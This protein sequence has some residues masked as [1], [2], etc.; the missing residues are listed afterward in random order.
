MRIGDCRPVAQSRHSSNGGLWLQQAQTSVNSFVRPLDVCR[1]LK[2]FCF[3]VV[4]YFIRES[5]RPRSDQPSKGYQ[6]LGRKSCL[7]ND[8][9]NAPITLII[10]QQYKSAEFGLS[11]LH[12]SPLSPLLSKWSNMSEILKK[13]S[14]RSADDWTMSY[15]TSVTLTLWKVG[16][17][18]RLPPKKRPG[19]LLSH[20]LLSSALPDWYAGKN[21]WHD[22][23]PQVAIQ[24]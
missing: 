3:A 1:S 10:L 21:G 16:L 7:K 2:P 14:G 19:N 18:Y 5:S 20:Q 4:L 15:S 24:H 6:R 23:R 22:G 17:Q 9:D 12:R 8:W 13:T 11:F